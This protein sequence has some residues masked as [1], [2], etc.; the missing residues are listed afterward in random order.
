MIVPRNVNLLLCPVIASY[1]ATL[2]SISIGS[3]HFLFTR[4]GRE[5]GETT[6]PNLACGS[7]GV[8]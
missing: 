8:S 6:G 7:L 4:I 5:I 1:I 3:D 2:I